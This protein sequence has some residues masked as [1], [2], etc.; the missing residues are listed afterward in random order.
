MRGESVAVDT[1]MSAES[2]EVSWRVIV[3][4]LRASCFV[5]IEGAERESLFHEK[6]HPKK[7]VGLIVERR[8]TH[9]I[10]RSV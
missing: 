3:Q 6:Q 2:C 9:R 10:I 8:H 1:T 4:W 7:P 5:C